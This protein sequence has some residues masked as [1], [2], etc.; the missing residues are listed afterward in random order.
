M[1]MRLIYASQSLVL[2]TVHSSSTVGSCLEMNHEN[3]MIQYNGSAFI[4]QH[5]FK[6]PPYTN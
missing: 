1:C 5:T 6:L 4:A 3:L 2:Y